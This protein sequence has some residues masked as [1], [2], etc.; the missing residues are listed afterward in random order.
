MDNPEN[1]TSASGVSQQGS[2]DSEE[3][4]AN[5]D[6]R[7]LQQRSENVMVP[8]SAK[9]GLLIFALFVLSFIVIM[10]LRGVL[11]NAPTLFRFF[12]NIYL[13]GMFPSR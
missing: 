1:E 13:A 3:N 6:R 8:Y 2:I 10:V 4:E 9:V 12:T 11:T 7:T 5:T